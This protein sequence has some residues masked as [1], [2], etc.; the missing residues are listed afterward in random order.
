MRCS[1]RKVLTYGIGLLG[2]KCLIG[3]ESVALAPPGDRELALK[4]NG[5][6]DL[7]RVH[8][9]AVELLASGLK[10]GTT[11]PEVWIRDTNT[12]IEMALR[13][14]KAAAFR[15]ALLNFLEFQGETGD[16]VDGYAPEA[17]ALEPPYR[18]SKRL[19]GLSAHKNNVESDQESSLVSATRKYVSATGDRALLDERVRGS[20]VRERLALALEYVLN[21]RFDKERGLIWGGTTVDWGDVQPETNPGTHVNAQTHRSV[22]IYNNAMAL[23]AIDDFVSLSGGDDAVRRRWTATRARLAERVREHLWDARREQFRPHLYLAGS[24][25]PKEFR[26]EDIY[27]HGGTAIAIEAGLLTRKEAARALTRMRENVSA[28]GAPSI[29]L[30]IY[31]PYP[32]GFFK[33]PIL[34]EPYT[35]QNGGDWCWFGGRMVQQLVR[36]KMME[37]AYIELLPMTARVVKTGKFY[38]WWS[39]DNQPRG[40]AGF[41]G[42]AGVLGKAIVMLQD[43]AAKVIAVC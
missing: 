21:E 29:G 40:S 7:K 10:A 6:A 19:P 17:K 18:L 12:F 35:Y 37:D 41:K 23:I 5:N 39:K 14:S 2:A 1:R 13:T 26:E 25:F 28:S 33:D 15:E 24:P 20:S 31:P 38:E 42:S 4:I 43:W 27:Y 9:L 30:T 36:L 34:T 32:S 16:I 11:Y 8:D 22:S 3:Q